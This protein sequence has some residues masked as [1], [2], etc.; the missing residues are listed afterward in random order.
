MKKKNTLK[1]DRARKFK[2]LYSDYIE[3]SDRYLAIRKEEDDSDHYKLYN[4]FNGKYVEGDIYYLQMFGRCAL[5]FIRSS[6][7]HFMLFYP[8]G[9]KYKF[10]HEADV[11]R[12]YS[13]EIGIVVLY[14]IMLNMVDS[15]IYFLDT[16]DNKMV[17]IIRV[18]PLHKY[19]S[20][21]QVGNKNMVCI[22]YIG[23]KEVKYKFIYI[24]RTGLYGG[25]VIPGTVKK[26]VIIEKLGKEIKLD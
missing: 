7:V 22:K 5:V 13:N 12:N 10:T 3:V 14:E 15:K 9:E 20:Y 23:E 4:T 25:K 17:G 6:K 19:I 24:D 1:E 26:H 16:I 2:F 8:T 11:L 21:V 18:N